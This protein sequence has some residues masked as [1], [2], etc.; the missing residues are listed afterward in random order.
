MKSEILNLRIPASL[1]EKLE[2]EANDNNLTL[3][4]L[5]RDILLSHYQNNEDHNIFLDK[6]ITL[7]NSNEFLYLITWLFEKR[8]NNYDTNNIQVFE[9][10]KKNV[11]KV[12]NDSY[13][14]NELKQE[15]EK[16]Y[17]DLSRFIYGFDLPN[18]YF[19]FCIPNQ[20]QSFNYYL[21][22]N[23]IYH[24]AFENTISL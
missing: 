7:Y 5:S 15:F 2:D 22:V 1:K 9:G 19:M 4:D 11:M 10:L 13:F 17:V 12:M 8:L 23:F 24:K 16:V 3:S 6:E 18:N 14:P 21:L 20:P